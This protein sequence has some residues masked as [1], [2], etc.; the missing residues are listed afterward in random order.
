[1][2]NEN[3]SSLRIDRWLWFARFFKTRGL[4]SKA[5]NGG[6]VRINGE[7]AKP[8][9]KVQQGDVIEIVRG[10]MPFKVEAGALPARRGP[11]TEARR[12]YVED[13]AVKQKRLAMGKAIREDRQSMPRT[14]GRPDKR[15]QRKLRDYGRRGGE[16]G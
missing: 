13:E 10:Q 15:T 8:G 12:C 4:A 14:L 5:V 3:D 7:R 2:A 16:S 1:M 9:S 6:H 11:A